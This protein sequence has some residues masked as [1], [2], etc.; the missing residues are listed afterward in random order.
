MSCLEWKQWGPRPKRL[1]V[2]PSFP[3]ARETQ[4]PWPLTPRLSSASASSPLVLLAICFPPALPLFHKLKQPSNIMYKPPPTVLTNALLICA[5]KPP[6]RRLW[7]CL[8]HFSH[9][10]WHWLIGTFH[11]QEC[12]LMGSGVLQTQVQ[13]LVLP[14]P[15]WLWSLRPPHH[16]GGPGLSK[17]ENSHDLLVGV[18]ILRLRPDDS[19]MHQQG[20]WDTW[21]T[22][23]PPAG[24]R[25][26]SQPCFWGTCL[27]AQGGNMQR[28]TNKPAVI[29][30]AVIDTQGNTDLA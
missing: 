14:W 2:L 7:V 13:M 20:I 26:G 17:E 15:L 5:S 22:Y 30:V 27:Q 4:S 3:G 6:S 28:A 10:V 29:Q 9:W 16:H 25:G 23:P 24:R 8:C 19:L 21:L 18:I 1:T 11:Q 12:Q